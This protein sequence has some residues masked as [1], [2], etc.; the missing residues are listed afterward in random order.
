MSE[1]AIQSD[2]KTHVDARQELIDQMISSREAQIKDEVG[3]EFLDKITDDDPKDDD[4]ETDEDP[5]EEPK[6]KVKVDGEEL[7]LPLTEILKGYQKDQAT[8]KRLAQAAQERQALEEER[9]ELERLRV[10][11]ESK[12]QPLPPTENPVGNVDDPAHT[13][14]QKLIYGGEDEGVEAL[15]ELLS[16]RK[17]EAIPKEQIVAEAANKAIL[18]MQYNNAE[19]QFLKDNPEIAGDATLY[20]IAMN[21]LQQAIPYSRTY[22]EAFTTAA[23]ETKAWLNKFSTKQEAVSE[24]QQRKEAMAK[25]PARS[26]AKAESFPA[27]KAETASEIIVNMRKQRGLPV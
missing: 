3:E 1:E 24:K 15:N 6:Y 7:E 2:A 26:N 5:P 18:Q 14:Y 13:L 16:G 21:V 4:L 22:D 12:K 23:Q 11:L 8:S 20:N 10:E 25:E 17:Q 27:Q 9:A 19:R